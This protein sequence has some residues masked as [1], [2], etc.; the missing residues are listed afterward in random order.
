MYVYQAG[1]S[2]P[3]PGLP[4]EDDRLQ[5]QQLWSP[6]GSAGAQR[7]ARESEEWAP[8]EEDDR[9]HVYIYIDMTMYTHI[10]IYTIIMHIR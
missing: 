6:R 5:C 9:C 3:S 8:P 10:Y 7:G 4:L 2:D 1:Y